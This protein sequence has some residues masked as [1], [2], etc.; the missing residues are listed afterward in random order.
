MNNQII[1]LY[2]MKS[3]SRMSFAFERLLFVG[4]FANSILDF[5]FKIFISYIF[6]PFYLIN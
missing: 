3:P 5:I 4:V 1:G 2:T 6:L